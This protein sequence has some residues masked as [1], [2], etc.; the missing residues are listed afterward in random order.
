MLAEVEEHA[1]VTNVS[2]NGPE[3]A[4]LSGLAEA[5]SRYTP[6]DGSHELRVPGVYAV[7]ATR[8]TGGLVHG[9]Y[10]PSLCIVSQGSKSV[11]LG[12]DVYQ[13]DAARM[14]IVSVEL[15]VASQ[16]TQASF[17]EPF[18]SLKLDLDPQK[19]AELALKVYPNGFPPHRESRGVTVSAAT[20]EIV[21]A[22]TRLLELMNDPQDAL[23][24][25]PLVLE[26][27]LVRLLRSPIG[28]RVAQVSR[29][30]SSTQRIARAM[31]W[32]R[33]NFDQPMVVEQLAE[34]VHMSPSTFHQHFKAVTSMSPLQFQKALRLREARRLMLTSKMDATTASRQVGYQSP[35]Q[36]SRE[37]GRLFGR[38]P[39][40][41]IAWLRTE[42]PL[43]VSS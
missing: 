39:V 2:P 24:L 31:A 20:T 6:Y 5:L 43:P 9:L 1:T 29:E 36:F 28:G 16:I 15:P 22:G 33:T 35:S 18:L 8:P 10:K 11:F 17:S 30:E 23:L 34:M 14:L 12:P 4:S 26:E 3:Q 38:A 25:A 27:I 41:D 40:R 32:V 21:K 42:G 7:R 19:I 37:Y 13:Y